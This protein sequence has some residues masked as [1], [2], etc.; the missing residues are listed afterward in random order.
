MFSVI[1]TTILIMIA[2]VT[3][4]MEDMAI[5]KQLIRY[6]FNLSYLPTKQKIR[7]ALSAFC[8]LL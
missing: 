3:M 5:I 4:I 2:F 7:F 8:T 6:K 1:I